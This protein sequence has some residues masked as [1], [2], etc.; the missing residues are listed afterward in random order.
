M[1]SVDPGTSDGYDSI[2]IG[3]GV[4]DVDGAKIGTVESIDGQ[5]GAIS[6]ATNPFAQGAVVV[7]FALIQWINRREL[8]L[9]CR[10]EDLRK[11]N[12]GG[13]DDR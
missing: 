7:P 1:R 11:S 12:R 6:I 5:A 13:K 10:E 9:S 4:Y 2:G 3:Q 8:F